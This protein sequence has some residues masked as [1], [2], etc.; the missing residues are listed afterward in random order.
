MSD[1]LLRL[2]NVEAWY[3]SGQALFGISLS[4]WRG[5]IVA[6]LGRNG[7][8]KSTSL[9]SVMQI[10]V[11]TRGAI[12]YEGHDLTRHSTTGV[13]RLGIGYVPED[14]RI[15]GRMTVRENLLLGRQLARGGWDAVSDAA[16][17]EKTLETFPMLGPLLDRRGGVLSGGEQQLLAIARSLVGGPELMLLDEPS[18]GLAPLTLKQVRAAIES[19]HR[20]FGVTVLLAEQNATFALALADRVAVIDTGRV[21]FTGKTEELRAQP[22]LMSRY[23]G[24]E[25]AGAVGSAEA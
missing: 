23:L 21:V 18:E 14:R 24:V 25:S 2:D 20:D 12:T 6:L 1:A 16:S 7:A 5:E 17:L 9:R 19:A 3:G 22:E 15:F 8:G 13:A 4:V 10:E 11:R